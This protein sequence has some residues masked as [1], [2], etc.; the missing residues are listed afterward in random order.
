MTQSDSWTTAAL[1]VNVLFKLGLVLLLIYSSVIIL[2]RLQ[3]SQNPRLRKG[4]KIIETTHLS[5]HRAI[6]LVQVGNQVYLIGATD[7]EV[8]M[9]S[10]VD[11]TELN[12]GVLMDNHT[13][14]INPLP[15]PAFAAVFVDN[16]KKRKILP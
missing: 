11:D 15:I 5:P 8:T 1:F 3:S 14:E 10:K 6:H 4:I 7:H 12:A 13:Q 2:R 16:L 9:L